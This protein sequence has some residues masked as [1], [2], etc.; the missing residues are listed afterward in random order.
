MNWN[1]P[2]LFTIPSGAISANVGSISCNTQE[3]N[4]TVVGSAVFENKTV[5]LSYTTNNGGITW[6]S[7]NLLASSSSSESGILAVTCNSTDKLC[8]S[9]GYTA[10]PTLKPV[11]Y[12]SI[13]GGNT[14]SSPIFPIPPVGTTKSVLYG[15]AGSQ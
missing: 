12:T 11:A 3:I 2:I 8:S 1:G 4:C 14:W 6:S 5:P 10:L 9:V 13:D 7:P 15:I